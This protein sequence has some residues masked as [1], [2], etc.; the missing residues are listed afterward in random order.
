[1][2]SLPNLPHRR[3]TD[4]EWHQLVTT[5]RAAGFDSLSADE[6]T[7]LL[8]GSAKAYLSLVTGTNRVVEVEG[9]GSAQISERYADEAGLHVLFE[10]REQTSA[11]ILTGWADSV[12]IRGGDHHT[13]S[14]VERKQGDVVVE[15]WTLDEGGPTCTETRDLG[16]LGFLM[17]LY[18][19][20]VTTMVTNGT[21]VRTDHLDGRRVLQLDI[22]YGDGVG[23]VWLDEQSL[24]PARMELPEVT[25]DGMQ[26]QPSKSITITQLNPPDVPVRP[27]AVCNASE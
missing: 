21:Y 5:Q 26:L 1:D 14:F 23:R 10:T 20:N 4:A 9:V 24:F 12:Y 13:W 25:G 15:D 27:S 11:Q 3:V 7:T 17:H 8:Q 16:G 18:Y 6:Q 22:P 19:S 2:L